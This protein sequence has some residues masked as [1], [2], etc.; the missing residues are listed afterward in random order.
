MH[1]GNVNGLYPSFYQSLKNFEHDD[2]H[3]NE[4]N[5]LTTAEIQQKARP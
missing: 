3:E 4:K 2:E 1:Q 5:Q